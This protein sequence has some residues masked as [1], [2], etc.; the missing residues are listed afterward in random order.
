MS[1]SNRSNDDPILAFAVVCLLLIIGL[2]GW[3]EGFKRGTESHQTNSA[4]AYQDEHPDKVAVRCASR[5]AVASQA[6]CISKAIESA[7]EQQRSEEDLDAQQQ[8]AEWARYML[9]VSAVTAIVTFFGV[10]YVAKTL[11]ATSD[12]LSVAN[13]ANQIMRDEGRPWVTLS[14]EADCNFFDRGGYQGELSWNFNLKNKGKTPAHSINFDV[15][16][17]KGKRVTVGLGELRQFAAHCVAEHSGQSVPILFPG[18]KTEFVRFQG[19]MG[20]T[21]SIKDGRK[22]VVEGDYVTI[23]FCLTYRIGLEEDGE[24]GIEARAFSID[25]KQNTIG[26]WGSRML[27]FADQRIVQ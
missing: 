12:T 25:Q 16:A 8:M 15:R 2:I 4:Q 3:Q 18:E 10:I 14:R 5:P 7:R 17:I 11:R 22:E 6:E 13:E 21:Y 26:P 19:A 20:T 24:I 23:L 9:Y 1:D 27:E